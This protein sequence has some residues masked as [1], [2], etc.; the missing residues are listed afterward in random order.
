MQNMQRPQLNKELELIHNEV[1]RM[2]SMVEEMISM[3]IRSLVNQDAELAQKAIEY[4]DEIDAIET[5]IVDRSIIF[6]AR[7]HPLASDLREVIAVTKLTTDLERIGDHCVDI[8]KYTLRLKDQKYIKE[9]IDIPKMAGMVS[10][11]VT[12]SLNA[13]VTKDAELARETWLEDDK[14]DELY[15]AIY[16]ELVEMMEDDTKKVLQCTAF[17]SII[18]HLERIGDYSTNICE[19]AV[20]SIEGKYGID[21]DNE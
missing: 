8:A 1:L 9:L 18:S 19:R 21:R 7:Q 20:Y 6:I 4:D 3:V 17:I 11:M 13:F 15:H 2:G 14:I 10:K 5:V 12:Q 16:D